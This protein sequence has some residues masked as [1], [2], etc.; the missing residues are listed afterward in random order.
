MSERLTNIEFINKC[1]IIHKDKYD[2]SLV[3]FVSKNNLKLLRISYKNNNNIEN[4][5][6]NYVY[7]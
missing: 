5:L 4:E 2:Y 1:S 3:S 7:I 6:K